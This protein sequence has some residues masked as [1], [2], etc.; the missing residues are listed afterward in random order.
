MITICR[1]FD[2]RIRSSSFRDKVPT[3]HRN[4]A[5]SFQTCLIQRASRTALSYGATTSTTTGPGGERCFPITLANSAA[6]SVSCMKEL[7][8]FDHAVRST[9]G[10]NDRLGGGPPEVPLYLR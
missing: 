2:R 9:H 6:D 10:C 1:G 3:K 5:A 4:A 7:I 8:G